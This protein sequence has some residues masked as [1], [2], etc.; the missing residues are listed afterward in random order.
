MRA[1]DADSATFAQARSANSTSSAQQAACEAM[2]VQ[3]AVRQRPARGSTRA[4]Q[5]PNTS[6]FSLPRHPSLQLR[7]ARAPRSA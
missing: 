2:H 4:P 1:E 5:R 7:A 3:R 6:P